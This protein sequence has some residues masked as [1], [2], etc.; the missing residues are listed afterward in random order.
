MCLSGCW[1]VFEGETKRYNS[2]QGDRGSAHW[3]R[4][5]LSD[6]FALLNRYNVAP[7]KE[8]SD[9]G[10]AGAGAGE[11]LCRG[12]GRRGR[13]IV[14]SNREA[15]TETAAIGPSEL[16]HSGSARIGN[17]CAQSLIRWVSCCGSFKWVLRAAALD[18][19]E[20]PAPPFLRRKD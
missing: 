2:T 9:Y 4:A 1:A 20:F 12:F 11:E 5:P 17:S 13:L 18:A 14:V 15:H 3:G 7:N 8:V 16:W 10:V 6:T 19:T